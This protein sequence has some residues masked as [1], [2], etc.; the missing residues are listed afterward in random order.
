MPEGLTTFNRAGCN[1]NYY[2]SLNDLIPEMHGQCIPARSGLGNWLFH[3][4]A[5]L[6]LNRIRIR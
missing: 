2:L 1:K 3:F 6:F 5:C 4:I